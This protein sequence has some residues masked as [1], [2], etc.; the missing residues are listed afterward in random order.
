MSLQLA[1]EEVSI[2]FKELKKLPFENKIE[3]KE[4]KNIEELVAIYFSI[5]Q[6]NYKEV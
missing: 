6:K 4:E 3:V 2:K 1:V 5:P